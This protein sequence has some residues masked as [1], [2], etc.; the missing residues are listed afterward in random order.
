VVQKKKTHTYV[1]L[2]YNYVSAYNDAVNSNTRIASSHVSDKNLLRIWERMRRL[3][4]AEALI[5]SLG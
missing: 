4:A 2:L 5:Y 3:K 1:N